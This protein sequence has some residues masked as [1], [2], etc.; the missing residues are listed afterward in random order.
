MKELESKH[1][2][3]QDGRR[4]LLKRSLANGNKNDKYIFENPQLLK[5]DSDLESALK[6]IARE[7]QGLQ[8]QTNKHIN[9]RGLEDNG[10]YA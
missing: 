6:E 7:Y 1:L 2:V 8:I 9:R 5:Q 3:E 4:V 10:L